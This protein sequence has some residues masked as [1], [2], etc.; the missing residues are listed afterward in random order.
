MK[1]VA[2]FRPLTVRYPATDMSRI[3]ILADIHGNLPALEAVTK[4]LERRPV[5]EILVGGDLVGRGPGG[6]SVIAAVRERG[7]PSIRGNHEDYLLDFYHRRVPEDWWQADEWAASRWMAAE[8]SRQDVGYIESLPYSMTS[9]R[10]PGLYLAHGTPRSAN[11]GLGPWSSDRTL[12]RHLSAIAQD[13]LVVAHT[14][15]P[16]LREVACGRVVN[17]G[18]VGLPF[19]GDRRAQYAVLE[20]DG[21]AGDWVVDFRRVAYDLEETLAIYRSSGFLSVGGATARLLEM[22]LRQARPYLVPFLSWAS[23]LGVA[24]ETEALQRCATA[25]RLELRV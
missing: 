23:A 10:E 13:L 12:E 14:H 25:A 9:R 21:E 8:L 1:T 15:R 2:S 6:S 11:E 16:M 20:R 4:D 22:E 24:P 19:N 3:A 18:S 7:W 5:D 17:V